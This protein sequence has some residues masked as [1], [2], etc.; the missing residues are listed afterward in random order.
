MMMTSAAQA[1][2]CHSQ[3]CCVSAAP[4][5]SDCNPCATVA[6]KP[7]CK[8][9]ERTVM[10]PE[11]VTEVRKVNCTAYRTETRQRDVTIYEKVPEIKEVEHSYTVMVPEVR[12]R[13]GRLHKRHI[14][15][16]CL[17]MNQKPESARL[18][19]L[20]G[21]MLSRNTWS[22]FPTPKNGQQPARFKK[23]S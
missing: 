14:R 17:I 13:S 8:T 21:R 22:T 9:V 6:C 10:V 16:M 5:V 18:R 19:K 3:Q 23:W 1:G 15:S 20:S 7:A 12:T 4:C 2:K 11:M